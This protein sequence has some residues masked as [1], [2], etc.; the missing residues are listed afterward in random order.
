[1]ITKTELLAAVQRN[2]RTLEEDLSWA[3]RG[4]EF[5]DR[6][7]DLEPARI[8]LWKF[9]KAERWILEAMEEGR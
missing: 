9:R 3:N 8:R 7:V 1:M 2:I 6:P 4:N 5:L